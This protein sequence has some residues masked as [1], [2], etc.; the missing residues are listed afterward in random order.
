M[1]VSGETESCERSWERK[2]GIRIYYIKNSTFNWKKKKKKA[3]FFILPKTHNTA[4]L[5]VTPVC[6]R[7]RVKCSLQMSHLL[8]LTKNFLKGTTMTSLRTTGWFILFTSR[9]FQFLI[10][11]IQRYLFTLDTS[12]NSIPIFPFHIYNWMHIYC[13][14]TVYAERHR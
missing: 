6:V 8:I 7:D 2:M 11:Q 9:F 1:W 12:Y 4:Q 10:T 13:Q 5:A 14:K 3:L